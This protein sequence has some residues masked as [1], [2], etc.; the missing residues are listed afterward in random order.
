MVSVYPITWPG[1]ALAVSADWVIDRPG[2]ST[3]TAGAQRGS[4]LPAGQLLPGAAVTSSR[5]MTGPPV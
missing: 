1:T 4:V 2:I 5:A 3:S